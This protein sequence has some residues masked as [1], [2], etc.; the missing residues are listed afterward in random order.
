[1]AP[2]GVRKRGKVE[3]FDEEV[4][5][6]AVRADDGVLYP[7]HCTQ[8]VD[9]SRAVAVGTEVGFEVVA[10]HRGTWE[11]RQLAPGPA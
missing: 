4:G 11:A 8:L 2:G 7:F 10:G 5:L 9:G 3:H 1:M 6:G